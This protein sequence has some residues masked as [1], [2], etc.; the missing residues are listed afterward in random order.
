MPISDSQFFLCF[1]IYLK[2]FNLFESRTKVQSSRRNQFQV[3]SYISLIH[4]VWKFCYS[5]S[6]RGIRE[7]HRGIRI[8]SNLVEVE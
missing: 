8:S 6:F 2:A 4:R 5:S 1:S 3:L 7:R